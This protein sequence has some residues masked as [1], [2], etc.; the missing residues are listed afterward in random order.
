MSFSRSGLPFEMGGD[1]LRPGL[2]SRV[3]SESSMSED[4]SLAL[5]LERTGNK[6]GTCNG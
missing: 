5:V 2:E 6:G 1:G 4:A 3:V